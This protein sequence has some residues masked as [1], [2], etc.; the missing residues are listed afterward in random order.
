MN[1]LTDL[2]QSIICIAAF[3]ANGDI[4]KLKASLNQGLDSGLTVNQIKAILEQMYAYAG[5]PRSLNG[6]TAFLSVL[7]QRKEQGIEDINGN[8][9]TATK[10]INSLE[11][12]T[13]NQ[14]K[15]VG[16]VVSGAIFDFSPEIERFLKAHLFGDIFH[17]DILTWQQ[18]ELATIAGLANIQGVNAQLLAHYQISLHNG[19]TADQLFDFINLL[20]I[21][22]GKDIADNAR[23]TLQK[24]I[25]K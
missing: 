20:S 17:N 4:D 10:E 15:L 22:C 25:K 16:Q 1:T 21:K 18:R 13:K 6:L 19:I 5:F 23:F 12:G 14:T 11:I 24:I 8:N 7:E 9:S 2:Q 3:T